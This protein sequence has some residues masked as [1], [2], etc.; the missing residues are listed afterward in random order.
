MPEDGLAGY[1]ANA[2]GFYCDPRGDVWIGTVNGMSRYKAVKDRPNHIAPRLVVES[3]ELKSGLLPFPREL[4]LGWKDRSVTFRTALLAFKGH[5]RCGYRARLE[6]FESDWLPL[7]QATELRYTNL[8]PGNHR[9]LLQAVN[10]SGVWGETVSLPIRVRPPFWLTWW[11]RVSA[12]ALVGIA[13]VAAHRWRLLIL[14][15][16]N[17]E[18]ERLV[19]LRTD[20][21][22]QANQDLSYLAGHDA[23][24]GLPNRRAILEYLTAQIGP[25][26]EGV[27]RFGLLLLDLDNFKKV[28][29][30]LGHAAGDKILCVMAEKIQGGLRDEDRL[31]RFGGDEFLLVLPSADMDAT[32]AVARRVSALS[33]TMSDEGLSVTVT[34]SCGAV[35]VFGPGTTDEATVVAAADEL[36]Y[37]V[38]KAGRK[39]YRIAAL[40]NEAPQLS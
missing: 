24:T 8:P 13:A 35:A 6:G 14:R 3:A 30:G 1:E 5:R 22:H 7:R 20:E 38:K 21:L 29:D 28:N 27:R 34:I 40:K 11:F 10:E 16:R 31:G 23:L 12:L 18:L 36:L 19:A 32:E 2:N 25:R 39:D 33:H 9:L 26:Q 37:E 4:D 15:R 17:E